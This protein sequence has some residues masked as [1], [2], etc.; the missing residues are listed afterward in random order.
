MDEEKYKLKILIDI[1]KFSKRTLDEKELKEFI[2]SPLFHNKNY[3]TSGA[4]LVKKG[5]I[6]IEEFLGL[7][8]LLEEEL[9]E[10]LEPVDDAFN[11]FAS[12]TPEEVMQAF[13]DMESYIKNNPE[14]SLENR[15]KNQE[16]YQKIKEHYMNLAEEIKRGA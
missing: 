7:G 11:Y 15:K 9:R 16:R 8:N 10:F 12:I 5:S 4:L 3:F 13:Q 6:T 2:V 1:L 14:E